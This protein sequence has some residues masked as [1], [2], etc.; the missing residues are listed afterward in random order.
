MVTINIRDNFADVKRALGD[1][2]RQMPFALS[3]AINRT[4]PDVRKA[5]QDAMR[6][7]FDRPTRYTLNSL[8]IKPSTKA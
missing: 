4:L 3:L 1:Q 6:S 7:G 5:E 8:Y 2:Q